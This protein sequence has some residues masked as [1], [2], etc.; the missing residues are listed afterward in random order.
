M[1]LMTM[2]E[3]LCLIIHLLVRIF[4]AAIFWQ[5]QEIYMEISF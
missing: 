3:L 4:K 1:S 2:F 5:E